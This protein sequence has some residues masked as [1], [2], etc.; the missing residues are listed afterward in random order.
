[1]R[2]TIARLFFMQ[3]KQFG[4]GLQILYKIKNLRISNFGCFEVCC[5]IV[6]L[7]VVFFVKL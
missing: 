4:I 7:S 5:G 2:V 3:V 6:L 1:M